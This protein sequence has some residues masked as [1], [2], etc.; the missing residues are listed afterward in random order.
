M[1]PRLQLNEIL[2]SVITVILV[3]MVDNEMINLMLYLSTP[4]QIYNG[5]TPVDVATFFLK[6]L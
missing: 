3:P 2:M 5:V 4:T 1:I 6:P